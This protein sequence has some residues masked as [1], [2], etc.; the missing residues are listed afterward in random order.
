[1]TDDASRNT[2]QPPGEG[3]GDWV[4]VGRVIGPWGLKGDLKI[5]PDTDSPK[6]FA[7]D[8]ALYLN[9]QATTVARSRKSRQAIVVKLDL[10]ND[11]THAESLRGALLTIPLADLEPLP[12]GTFYHFE[13]V[14]ADVWTETGQFL[15]RVKEILQT[16]AHDVYVVV[17]GDRE[18]LVPAVADIVLEV[19][20]EES[21][22]VVRLPDGL[23]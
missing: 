16:G 9:G 23:A 19:S 5:E 6:R 20:V 22:I 15:G 7:P 11:R 17:Q 8:S 2:S 18:V 10:V 13:I 1:M 12:E 14:D 3:A 4:V 21:K